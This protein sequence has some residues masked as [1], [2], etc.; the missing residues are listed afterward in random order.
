MRQ[1]LPPLDKYTGHMRLHR[2]SSMR[3]ESI[4]NHRFVPILI[5][6]ARRTCSTGEIA[7]S[8]KT[9]SRGKPLCTPYTRCTRFSSDIP[10]L[11]SQYC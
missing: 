4:Q 2:A 6:S 3:V 1:L 9:K 7:A 11:Y 10:L 8:K 5:S